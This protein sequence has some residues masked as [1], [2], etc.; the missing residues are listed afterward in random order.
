MDAIK[1]S[2]NTNYLSSYLF[3]NILYEY[4]H[5]NC[6]SFVDFSF[7][8]L[9]KFKLIEE[10]FE[11]GIDWLSNCNILIAKLFELCSILI[12]LIVL[13]E[14]LVIVLSFLFLFFIQ[15]C[16]GLV[17]RFIVT[18]CWFFS[19]DDKLV[20]ELWNLYQS[21]VIFNLIFKAFWKLDSKYFV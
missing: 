18:A 6:C 19:I 4:S 8:L 11:I 12:L 10:F 15:R 7:Y 5:L 13:L 1:W 14:I 9:S 3:R 2:V 21:F 16:F 17:L 20:C